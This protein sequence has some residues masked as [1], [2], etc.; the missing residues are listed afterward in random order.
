M[1]NNISYK[2]FFS[3]I[4]FTFKNIQNIFF[5]KFKFYFKISFL[6]FFTLLIKFIMQKT[7]IFFSIIFALIC[8]NSCN[9][10]SGEIEFQNNLYEYN[11]NYP[12]QNIAEIIQG[13]SAPIE[14]ANLIKKSGGKYS[15]EF[16][17]S[18]DLETKK[19]EL[20]KSLY[21]GVLGADLGYLTIYEK[22]EKVNG[23]IEKL[24]YISK[25][26]NIEQ[27]IDFNKLSYY[28][29]EKIEVDSLS[30]LSVN[31]FN[32]ID[33]YFRKN[34]QNDLSALMVCGIWIEGIYIASQ[35][36]Q[37]S[38]NKKIAEHLGEQKVIIDQLLKI[39]RYYSTEPVFESLMKNMEEVRKAYAPI[40]I[41]Y[42]MGEPETV[43]ENGILVIR[44]NEKTTVK[45]TDNQLQNI[46]K[47]IKILR[48][49]I[50]KDNL[51][52]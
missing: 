23:I 29:S 40:V 43:E 10:D 41:I 44:T 24:K 3:L 6:K 18:L 51:D 35:V 19:N 26:I 50:L 16:L 42:E 2:L 15:P 14:M 22:T 25:D 49:K 31:A 52:I 48:N 30:F 1:I 45:M 21:L 17:S 37:N 36:Q 11:N 39:L 33:E 12:E 4:F 38:S 34:Q 7:Y 27:F 28:A 13:F 20:E 5:I 9:S 47:Q 8:L 32:R 46:T